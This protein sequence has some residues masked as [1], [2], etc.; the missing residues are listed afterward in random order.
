MPS[1]PGGRY[2]GKHTRLT[3]ECCTID[4][5]RPPAR[6]PCMPVRVNTRPSHNTTHGIT[7][8]QS[9]QTV[10][11]SF[12]GAARAFDARRTGQWQPL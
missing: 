9:K 10:A 7:H 8:H 3:V 11:P 4:D 5:R 2:T 12:V 1:N 6:E